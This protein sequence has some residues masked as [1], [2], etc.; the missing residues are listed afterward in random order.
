MLLYAGLIIQALQALARVVAPPINIVHRKCGGPLRPGK[1]PPATP[2]P[3]YPGDPGTG[4]GLAPALVM[5]TIM[6]LSFSRNSGES[7]AAIVVGGGHAGCEAAM[8]LARMGHETLLISGNVD[9]IGHVSCNP[10]IGGVGKGH[11]VREI[12][13]LGGMMGLWADAAGIQFRTLNTGKGPAVRASRA[14]IDREAY[15]A[16]VKN[17]VL[18]QECLTVWQD[19]VNE[20]LSAQAADGAQG[21][22][23]VR[24]VLG[25]EFH[26]P[27]VIITAGTFLN[28]L[29]HVGLTNL[30]GGRLG[31]APAKGLSD[32][33]RRHCLKLGRLKTG[34]TPRLLSSSIDWESLQQFPGDDPFP[35]FSFHGPKPP[36]EQ[37]PC[38]VTWTNER[39]HEILRG[40]LDR[41]PMFSG[42]IKG[43][44]ARYCPSIEDKIFRFPDRERH[45]I[46][47]EPEG[48]NGRECYPNGVSTSM[49][50][51]VQIAMLRTVPGLENVKVVRPG[52]AIE[53]DYANPMDLKPTLESK[54]LPGLWL[55]GQVNGTSGYE[56]AAGQG[57]WAGINAARALEGKEPWILGRHE[58]YI[59]VMVDDLVTKGVDD[60]Y[61]MFTSRAEHRL[62]L[63][64]ANA[65]LRLTPQGRELGLVG[66]GQWEAFSRKKAL[67]AR[68]NAL[69]GG[70]RIKTGPETDAKLAALGEAPLTQST[71]L[72]ELLRRPNMT[73]Q[74]LT[75]LLPPGD[76][77]EISELR[78]LLSDAACAGVDANSY[79]GPDAN[80]YSGPDANSNI[81]PDTDF[82]KGSDNNPYDGADANPDNSTYNSIADGTNN[83]SG[84][85]NNGP[86]YAGS[87]EEG[88]LDTRS[89]AHSDACIEVETQIKYSGFLERQEK[90]AANAAQAKDVDLP[91]NIRYDEVAGLTRELAE[92][93]AKVRPRTCAQAERI[94]GMTPAA[95]VCLNI[96]ARKM[97]LQAK[98]GE[99]QGL[100]PTS[101]AQ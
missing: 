84:Y 62:L 59:A 32:S 86:G 3:W 14:Q 57:L 99:G 81:G 36:L 40:A 42:V 27:H 79:S 92:K 54:I 12:D 95:V 10:A 34:T 58:A 100:P 24:T 31:D 56:E 50:L 6:Q 15:A 90:L 8:A 49:P 2:V 41:S 80:S 29:I 1:F 69:L 75:T 4:M 37:R 64:E 25:R 11:M 22:Q 51:D 9:R 55:A 48:L 35:S 38:H 63:R 18:G 72:R 101:P 67:M 43:T 68:L 78:F 28:G 61:R 47:L 17:D 45:Q 13:A 65:D 53:Y 7:F 82:D 21:V 60:P 96:H 73:I 83:W 16:A 30:P 5:R 71:F 93:L 89:R 91:E 52:Y 88:G 23:G 87:G 20:I 26:A 98:T 85:A 33:L 39:T 97:T 46:F 76:T 19:E 77:A 74:M 94:P 66:A 70:M 44:G